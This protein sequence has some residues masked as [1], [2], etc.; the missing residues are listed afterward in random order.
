ML[1]FSTVPT[2]PSFPHQYHLPGDVAFAAPAGKNRLSQP[3]NS[4]HSE[5]SEPNPFEFI[6]ISAELSTK[7]GT[8]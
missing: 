7:P 3:R 1:Q 8:Q 5:S 6:N 4:E 2:T